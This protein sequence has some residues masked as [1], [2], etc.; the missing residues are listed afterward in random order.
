MSTHFGSSKRKKI[1]WKDNN[2]T[3]RPT[4]SVYRITKHILFSFT[5]QSLVNRIKNDELN[6][7]L[8]TRLLHRVTKIV[9]SDRLKIEYFPF[10]TQPHRVFVLPSHKTC[11]IHPRRIRSFRQRNVMKFQYDH[12]HLCLH[13]IKME[14]PVA[15]YP[16]IDEKEKCSIE[17]FYTKFPP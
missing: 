4:F 14:H 17:M 13:S 5:S 9:C 10:L 6:L 11:T 15:K 8:G 16:K 12:S 2:A 7:P 3:I 1:T